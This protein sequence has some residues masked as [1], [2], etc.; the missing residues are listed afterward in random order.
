MNSPATTAE[1]LECNAPLAP[2]VAGGLC[3]KCLLKLGLASQFGET[4][5]GSAGARKLVAPPQ[6]PFDFGGYR[7]LRLLGRGGMGAVYEAEQLASSRRVALKV[8]GQSIDSP[9]M[10][11]RFLREGR[12][13]A[14]VNHPNTVYIFGTEEIEGAPVIAMELIAGGTLRDEIKR[15]GPLPPREAVDA[16]L[17]IIAGLECAAAAGVLHRDVKPENCFITA[18]GVVKVGDFGLSVSTLA[19][20]DTQITASGTML[21]T[22]SYA[23]PEQ[24]RGDELDA[25]ADIYSVGAT[26]YAL[27]TGLAPFRGE[28]VV[29]VVAAV[30][31]TPAP[32]EPL[33]DGLPSGLADVVLR[34]LEKA[35]ARRYADY[36]QLRE[37]LLPF[38]SAVA[39][40]ATPA[41]RLAAGVIDE[42]ISFLPLLLALAYSGVIEEDLWLAQRTTSSFLVWLGFFFYHVAYFAL[43]EERWGASLG[44]ALLHLRVTTPAGAAP[45]YLAASMRALLYVFA[46][47]F[48]TILSAFLST[49]EEYRAAQAVGRDVV[50]WWL[51]LVPFIILFMTMR[52]KN[53]F[54]S[55]LDLVTG[56]RVVM[57]PS[58]SARRASST[59][60][61]PAPESGADAERIGPFRV[62]NTEANGTF[63][64]AFDDTLRRS[65]WVRRQPLDAPPIA[66]ERRAL[67]R[68]TRLRWLAGTRNA[69]EAWDAF[70]APAGRSFQEVA[71][72]GEPSWGE[73]RHWLLDLTEELDAASKD[74]TLPPSLS[75]AHVWIASSGRAV[76]LDEPWPGA[77]HEAST[78]PLSPEKL[79]SSLASTVE[80][81]SL[82]LHARQLLENF[83]SGALDRLS[84]L[85]G[86]LRSLLTRAV[87]F[88]RKRKSLSLFVAP[89]SIVVMIVMFTLL[90]WHERGFHDRKWS[91]LYPDRPPLSVVLRMHEAIVVD[92]GFYSPDWRER[93]DLV[94]AIARHL[95]DRYSTDLGGVLGFMGGARMDLP[96]SEDERT[97]VAMLMARHVHPDAQA[98]AEAETT[99]A[100]ALPAFRKMEAQFYWWFALYLCSGFLI[101]VAV[102]QFLTILIFGTTPG[103][104]MFGYAVV[105][106]SGGFAGRPRMLLRW[107]IAW[108]PASALWICSTLLFV[109]HHRSP[110]ALAFMIA[111]ALIWLAGLTAALLHPN[112]GPH[113]RLAGTWLVPR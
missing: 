105:N 24:L 40:P 106:E 59:V 2:N 72:A 31:N 94:P 15:R 43:P 25:R 49:A 26:L 82:P 30:L 51:F 77:S 20:H 38:S 67:G 88:D 103:Q 100:A 110:V 78:T 80:R 36:A 107:F 84:F 85:A 109:T 34:C 76:L 19:R 57:R 33:H 32:A 12:L 8:L 47:Q 56:T 87:T 83:A 70:E 73:M 48:T 22:P 98:L 79:I 50:P 37:A 21:G 95:A 65:V 74:D 54:A 75:L 104:R 60:H 111:A 101:F 17:Q 29:Q 53:G 96:L 44:K 69:S 63:V 16:I 39:V 112:R 42:V 28:N 4:S 64:S 61:S 102:A 113:D 97:V 86:N 10:R 46:L 71:T 99:L 3:P 23:P 45:G 90:L 58:A 13:A 27:L 14:A 6:F 108:L 41:I 7:V 1:C 55:L 62:L 18:E 91:A 52:R 5:V 9:E 68:A 11:K 92:F 93:Q 66:S 89:F 81:K 35:P